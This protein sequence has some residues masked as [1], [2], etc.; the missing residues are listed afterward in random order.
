MVSTGRLLCVFIALLLRAAPG[1]TQNDKQLIGDAV[2]TPQEIA[3]GA[4]ATF[5]VRFQ[6]VWSDTVY[7]MVVRD[8]LDPRF[9][10]ASFTMV[11]ASHPYELLLDGSN[12]VRWYFTQML[13]PDSASD[14]A[15]SIGFILYNVKPKPFIAPGQTI[16]NQACFTMDDYPE[17][18]TN[19]AYLW[20]DADAAVDNP[21]KR[22]DFF[23][24]PNPNYG[25]FEIRHA[26]QN[27]GQDPP[28]LSWWITDIHGKIISDGRA[29]DSA[30]AGNQVWLERPAP[31]LYLLWLKDAQQLTV[32]QFAIIR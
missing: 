20:I 21:E 10:A 18:C 11:A 22:S 4:A 1:F 32:Q 31:G 16:P 8:T 9:D 29:A 19:E 7:Q 26:Q 2:F 23:V 25:Q 6:N 14:F 24:A 15:G 3:E 28:K 5:L 17:F 30:A 13:L 12:V 27:T